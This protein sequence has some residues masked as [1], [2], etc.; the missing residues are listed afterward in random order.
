MKVIHG[1]LRTL[2]SSLAPTQRVRSSALD[3]V[4]S[5]S[6]LWTGFPVY[7][8]HFDSGTSPTEETS[9]DVPGLD[10]PSVFCKYAVFN[11]RAL[12]RAPYNLP[13]EESSSLMCSGLTPWNALYGC[14]PIKSGSWVLI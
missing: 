2:L 11:E 4:R 8:P 13:Y 14:K 9:H 5:A 1:F 10:T 3:Q 6:A 7:Y 12:A